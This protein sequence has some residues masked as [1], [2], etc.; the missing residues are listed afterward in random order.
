MNIEYVHASR[1]GNGVKVAEEFR[2]RMSERGVTVQVHHVRQANPKDMPRVDLYMFSSP[3]R[4]GRPRGCVRRFLKRL[5]VPGGSK[6]ALLTTEAVP[7]PDKAEEW[8]RVR[9]IMNEILGGRGLV[10]VAEEKVYVTGLGG[11]LEEGWEEK[12]DAFADSLL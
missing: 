10:K 6:Y 12:V 2:R 7:K 8:Q 3:G 5:T 1:F 11:P 9:P 4:M